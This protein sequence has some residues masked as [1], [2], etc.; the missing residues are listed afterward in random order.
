[1]KTRGNKVTTNR[2]PAAKAN[3]YAIRPLIIV[4]NK[5]ILQCAYWVISLIL[6]IILS[7]ES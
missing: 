5:N 4:L 6:V 3:M 1:M 7:K 2:I